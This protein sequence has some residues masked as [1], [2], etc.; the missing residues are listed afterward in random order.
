MNAYAANDQFSN[1]AS[2]LLSEANH[3][4]ANHLA[5]V[6]STIRDQIRRIANGPDLIRRD[7][8]SKGLSDAAGRI[9]A[10]ARL[11]RRLARFESRGTDICTLLIESANEIVEALSMADRVHIRQKLDVDCRVDAEQ[12]S[13]L[14]LIMSEIVT[15]AIK[16]AHP[17]DV[18]IQ[19]DIACVRGRE[20]HLVLEIAD[21]GV[22]LPEG[23][24][25]SRDGGMGLKLIRTFAE[26]IGASLAISSCDLGLTYL[27]ELPVAKTQSCQEAASP[28][29]TSLDGSNWS[30]RRESNARP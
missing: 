8:A 13:A 4:I 1:Q 28:K 14:V 25:E 22:G 12:A 15:N 21:D 20:G 10:I 3:R 30:G 7:V 5:L 16:Y 29:I 19:L 9:V 18:P 27:L 23:F 6:A 11:H 26:R 24:T 17:T 2:D